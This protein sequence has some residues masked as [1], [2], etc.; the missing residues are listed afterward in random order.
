MDVPVAFCYRPL[1][2]WKGEKLDWR[3]PA[4]T[5]EKAGRVKVLVSNL[6]FLCCLPLRE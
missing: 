1:P 2:N 6:C 5:G 4:E 3:E